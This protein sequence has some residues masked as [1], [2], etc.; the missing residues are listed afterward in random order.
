MT[1][2]NGRTKV[3]QLRASR[4]SHRGSLLEHS[5]GCKP[6]CIHRYHLLMSAPAHAAAAESDVSRAS[7]ATL[8]SL[9]LLL[10][11]C[12]AIPA[13]VFGL[14]AAYRWHAAHETA[15]RRVERLVGV[16]HE[17]ALK[18]L[19]N[20]ETLLGRVLEMVSNDDDGTVRAA[21]AALHEQLAAMAADKEQIQSIWVWGADGRPLAG[22]RFHPLPADLD[23]SDREF[24]RWHR[25]KRGGLYFTE[26]LVG[27]ATRDPFFDMSVGRYRA[28]GSFAGWSPWGSIP[29]ISGSFMPTSSAASRERWSPCSATTASCIRACQAGARRR[30]SRWT[31]P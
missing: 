16:A 3:A 9:R 10:V 6:K 27:K 22:N 2:I 19:D 20:N 21:E 8:G 5:L 29:P 13:V 15:T 23:V 28:D 26:P 14:F 1:R 31:A 7:S 18:V 12:V 25:E 17:H 30:A 4:A 11:L 24:F